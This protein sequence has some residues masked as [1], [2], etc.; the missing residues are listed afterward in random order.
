MRRACSIW[1]LHRTDSLCEIS[2][3]VVF[4]GWTQLEE[5][6]LKI[7]QILPVLTAWTFAFIDLQCDLLRVKSP[8]KLRIIWHSNVYHAVY[9]RL[10]VVGRVEWSVLDA[11]S[12]DFADVQVFLDLIHLGR[13]N[14]V[15]DP[16]DQVI[17]SR[18]M[19]RWSS[20]SACYN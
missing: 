16:P 15:G 9:V 19:L 2:D 10:S 6:L 7:E 17:V 8:Q 14:V 3:V 20:A 1:W 4:A 13:I 5:S 12:I 18:T 11:I